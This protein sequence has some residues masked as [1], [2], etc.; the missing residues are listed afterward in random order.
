M[1]LMHCTCASTNASSKSFFAR[2]IATVV[3]ST[4]AGSGGWES[5]STSM[6]TLLRGAACSRRSAPVLPQHLQ[7]ERTDHRAVHIASGETGAL[8]L[9]VV[10]QARGQEQN[11]VPTF[12]AWFTADDVYQEW[13][14]EDQDYN[15]SSL[16]AEFRS[17]EELDAYVSSTYGLL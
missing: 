16:M 5:I 17:R 7:T 1:R 4:A 10:Y 8:S 11:R 2:S 14:E 15:R 3:A 6:L 9:R 12:F 13:D